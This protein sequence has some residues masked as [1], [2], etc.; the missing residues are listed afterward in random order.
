MS[1]QR[2]NS[3]GITFG[4]LLAIAFIVL[5]LT[6]VI[7]WSWGW[8]L[9]PIW[10]S[11]IIVVVLTSILAI[12]EAKSHNTARSALERMMDERNELLRKQRESRK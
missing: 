12:L 10:I 1:I 5:K 6:H 9:A 4:G 11:F 2:R 8:V 3:G 7:D